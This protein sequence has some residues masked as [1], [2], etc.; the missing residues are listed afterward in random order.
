VRLFGEV[1]HE[2]GSRIWLTPAPGQVYRF[3]EAGRTM[4]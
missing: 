3:D 1:H 2:P 4:R